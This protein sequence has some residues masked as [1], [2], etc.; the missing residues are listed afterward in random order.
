M[1]AY[2]EINDD[3]E[4]KVLMPKPQKSI[5]LANLNAES[6]SALDTDATLGSSGASNN[7]VKSSI[8]SILLTE[9]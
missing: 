9:D 2:T 7:E 8:C 1:D 3:D 6:I 5:D 4:I